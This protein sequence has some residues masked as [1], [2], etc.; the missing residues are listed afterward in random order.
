[1]EDNRFI[2]DTMTWSFSRINSFYGG[3]RKE[4]KEHYIDCLDSTDSFDGQFGGFCHKILEMYFKGELTEFDL[5]QYY[6]DNYHDYVT[7]PCPYPNGD[8]KY[9]KGLE[10]FSNFS[11]PIDE[12]EVLGVEKEV[13]FKIKNEYDCVGYIDVLLRHKSTGEITLLDHK[14]STIKILKNGNISKSDIEHFEAFK[15]QQYLYSSVVLAEYGRVDKLAWNMFKDGTKIEIPWSQEA[16]D[17]TM[18]WAYNTIKNIEKETDYSAKPNYYYCV[19]LCSTRNNYCPYKRLG[20][21]Y[22][23]INSKCSN[24]KAKDYDSY[25]GLGV[26][27]CDEWKDKQKFFEWALLDT[28]YE[29]GQMLVRDDDFSDFSPENCHWEFVSE[30]EYYEP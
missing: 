11:F 19:N 22:D 7:I 5:A 15:R 25:G 18:D 12:Y 28:E 27:I 1:M 26:K 10:Y 30:E 6:E 3:C 4:W 29:D 16:L 14:S 9:E 23:G 20:M 8:T 24:P 2:I 21:I 17:D 13:R